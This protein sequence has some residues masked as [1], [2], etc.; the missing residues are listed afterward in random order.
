MTRFA[1]IWFNSSFKTASFSVRF[2]HG[3]L[4]FSNAALYLRQEYKDIIFLNNY[5][6]LVAETFV[7]E[8][9]VMPG[10]SMF[11]MGKLVV[12]MLVMVLVLWYLSR[13][14]PTRINWNQVAAH[15]IPYDTMQIWEIILLYLVQPLKS[16][17]AVLASAVVV[18]Q[19]I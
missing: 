12:W 16:S 14:G 13:R 10:K 7:L 5:Q 17:K 6:H 11:Q 8:Q 18:Q 1:T 15:H 2:F 4:E 3:S 19:C 9:T